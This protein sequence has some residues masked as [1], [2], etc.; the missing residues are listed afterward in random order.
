MRLAY[1]DESYTGESYWFGAI[2]VP[3]NRDAALQREVLSIPARYADHG[4]PAGAEIRG[5]PLWNA[6]GEWHA[7]AR[8]PWLRGDA[9]LRT[10]QTIR[11]AGADIVFVGIDRRADPTRRRLDVARAHAVDVMLSALER[12]CADRLGERCLLI[13]DEETSSLRQLFDVV[14]RHHRATL[15]SGADPMI[16]ERPVMAPSAE[17]PGVQVA[18]VTVYL[19][20]RDHAGRE[21]DPRAQA[22][23]DRLLAEIQSA[24]V[25]DIVP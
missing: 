3:E 2:L 14:H 16:V 17:T 10:A 4:V 19:R 1:I 21:R 24:I 7:L 9:M 25:C 23:R 6:T 13:F 15:M 22:T 8:A 20:Q 12:Q 5:Y 11:R 18:D